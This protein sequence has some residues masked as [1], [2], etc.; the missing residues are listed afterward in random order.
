MENLWA[1]RAPW[2]VGRGLLPLRKNPRPPAL[3]LR[4][5]VLASNEKSWPC[6]WPSAIQFVFPSGKGAPD[7]WPTRIAGSAGGGVVRPCV[8]SSNHLLHCCLLS[9][10]GSRSL[11]ERSR[12]D[13]NSTSD[14]Q[15][16][17]IER[18]VELFLGDLQHIQTH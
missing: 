5:S 7:L 11:C 4:P 9:T 16:G 12:N 17:H 3:G 14:D 15:S 8:T 1:V 13:P 2:L 10:G 18:F 6:P